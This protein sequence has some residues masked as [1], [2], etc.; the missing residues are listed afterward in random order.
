MDARVICST[1]L[2]ALRLGL[3]LCLLILAPEATAQQ[4]PPAKPNPINDQTQRSGAR[5]M[6]EEFRK[7]C[8][9]IERIESGLKTVEEADL[10]KLQTKQRRQALAISQDY[11]AR[12]FLKEDA[13]KLAGQAYAQVT[14]GKGGLWAETAGRGQ[15]GLPPE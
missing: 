10:A 4:A 11:Y 12:L 15:D 14:K 6:V 5:K 3:V 7:T 8:E 1:L 13:N 9:E 2:G